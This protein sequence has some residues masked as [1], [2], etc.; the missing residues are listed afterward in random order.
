MAHRGVHRSG[1]VREDHRLQELG[2]EQDHMDVVR[3]RI[4][5]PMKYGRAKYP[6]WVVCWVLYIH[7]GH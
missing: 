2:A 4:K 1:R 5:P 3:N 6:Q 7:K